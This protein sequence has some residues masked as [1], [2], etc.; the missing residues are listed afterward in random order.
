MKKSGYK[1]CQCEQMNANYG[2]GFARMRERLGEAKLE[3]LRKDNIQRQLAARELVGGESVEGRDRSHYVDYPNPRRK[4]R[5]APKDA[6]YVMVK[7]KPERVAHLITEGPEVSIIRWDDNGV[8][9]AIPNDQWKRI[10][11]R[12]RPR[13]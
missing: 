6:P 11:V 9:Q 8:E 12:K 4:M 7:W 13:V 10:V 3:E 1:L 2:P 5:K